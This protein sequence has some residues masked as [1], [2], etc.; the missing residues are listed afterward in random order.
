MSDGPLNP[1]D[2]QSR[3]SYFLYITGTIA[4]LASGITLAATLYGLIFLVRPNLKPPE[5]LG[6]S[7]T[8]VVI[9][10]RM[11]YD[12]YVAR[13]KAARQSFIPNDQPGALLYIQFDIQGFHNRT[14]GTYITLMDAKTNRPIVKYTD[15]NLLPW[16]SQRYQ[17]AVSSDRATVYGWISH[18]GK[19]GKYFVRVRLYDQGLAEGSANYIYEEPSIGMLDVVDSKTFTW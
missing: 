10:E 11:T 9:G 19:K 1:A 5:K 17:P 7:I 12:E 3:P 18:S 8:K 16:Q 14:Y 4:A 6:A 2:S 13:S 15:G